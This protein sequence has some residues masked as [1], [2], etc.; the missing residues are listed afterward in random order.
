MSADIERRLAEGQEVI[1]RALELAKHTREL[2]EQIRRLHWRSARH[3]VGR[4]RRPRSSPSAVNEQA[5]SG[6]SDAHDVRGDRCGHSVVRFTGRGTYEE[7]RAERDAFAAEFRQWFA[8]PVS[9][10][11][12]GDWEWTFC[13]E[14]HP[15]P[16]EGAS[17]SEQR[18]S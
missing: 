18:A 4:T 7:V 15:V 11:P 17:G 6:G 8:S 1:V 5:M 16:S 9:R 14:C 13:P 12:I 2:R 10:S 3:C